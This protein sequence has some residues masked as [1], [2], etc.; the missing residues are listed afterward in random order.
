MH[1]AIRVHACMSTAV[2]S[3]VLLSPK[4]SQSDVRPNVS[5]PT[6]VTHATSASSTIDISGKSSL[7]TPPRPISAVPRSRAAVFLSYYKP[8][9]GL[10]LADMACAL[11]VAAIT[12]ALPLCARYVTKDILDSMARQRQSGLNQI[13]LIGA[14]MV[15]LVGVHTLCVMFI[16]YQ[17]HIMGAKME[18]DMR[19]E[20]FEHLSEAVVPLL[21]R[22]D[23]RPTDDADDQRHLRDVR[24]VPPRP[25]GY[26]RHLPEVIGA[27]VILLQHQRRADADRCCSSLPI[28]AV[29]ALY[30]NRKYAS[31]AAQ[32]Q[33]S[34]RRHQRAGGRHAGRHPRGQVV[35]QRGGRRRASSPHEN[36]RFLASRRSATGARRISPA[37]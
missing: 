8:Y 26:R 36:K 19:R 9:K 34:R 18:G 2:R 32:Q 30:F 5:P 16:D 25:G 3:S 12:L 17:G 27:F 10:F 21:R 4:S 1:S 35:H 29:Y 7:D 15:A 24:A 13:Y 14:L 22:A 11:I 31:R 37:G 23:D 20:L 33:G 28:M 6:S